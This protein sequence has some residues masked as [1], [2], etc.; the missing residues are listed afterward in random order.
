MADTEGQE[1]QEG[2]ELNLLDQIIQEGGMVRDDS[3]MP[4]APG[5]H[6]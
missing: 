1:T 5:P 2:Q 6:W 4:Y 3:Q